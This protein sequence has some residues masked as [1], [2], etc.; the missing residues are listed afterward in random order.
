MRRII[1]S[2]NLVFVIDASNVCQIFRYG[3]Y[4]ESDIFSDSTCI[5]PENL[6]SQTYIQ[7]LSAWTDNQKI[8]LDEEKKKQIIFNLKTITNFQQKKIKR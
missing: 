5:A 2:A 4:V 7:K 1:S 3:A 8:C 6:K